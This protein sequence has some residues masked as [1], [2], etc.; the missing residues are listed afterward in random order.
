ML[1]KNL[2]VTA[3]LLLHSL[4]LFPDDREFWD[5]DLISILIKRSPAYQ[6]IIADRQRNQSKG[7]KTYDGEGP[8]GVTFPDHDL[9]T[10]I[11]SAD[12][13]LDGTI[14]K[15]NECY[16]ITDINVTVSDDYDFHWHNKENRPDEDWLLKAGNNGALISQ[17]LHIIRPYHW[18][19]EF[20]ETRWLAK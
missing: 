10:A 3:D 5:G 1:P 18:T 7:S 14:C 17:Y 8:I 13:Y 15:R 2:L 16:G 11:G 12:V 9:H 6:K 4:R 19:A 20:K